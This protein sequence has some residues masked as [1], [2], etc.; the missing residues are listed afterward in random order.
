MP[1][2][3]LLLF[4]IA[5]VYCAY[6]ASARHI[7][8]GGAQSK[9]EAFAVSELGRLTGAKFRTVNPSWLRWRNPFTGKTSRLELDGYNEK[10]G[11]AL[12]FSGPLHTKWYPETESYK[13]YV[14]R[15]LKDEAKK[16][17]C[18]KH[19]VCLIVLDMSLPRRHYRDYFASRLFDC[20]KGTRPDNYIAEQTAM[21][22]RNEQLDKQLFQ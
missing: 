19:G 17:I 5:I 8:S 4:L 6:L 7:V 16:E 20:N 21:P 1:S 12:E 13:E 14:T 22:Y 2:F 3:V 10:L 18:A 15:V 11:I 9:S